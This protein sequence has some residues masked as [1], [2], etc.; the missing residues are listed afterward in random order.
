ML[1]LQGH[2]PPSSH[3]EGGAHPAAPGPGG[4]LAHLWDQSLH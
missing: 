2:L 1:G 4:S 3:L